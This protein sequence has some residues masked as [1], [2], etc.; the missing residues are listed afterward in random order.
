MRDSVRLHC[1]L[2]FLAAREFRKRSLTTSENRVT[3]FE[4]SH[5]RTHRLYFSGGIHARNR[6]LRFSHTAAH[7]A[8]DVCRHEMRIQRID[9]RGPDTDQDLVGFWHRL[10]ELFEFQDVARR[11]VLAI[12]HGFHRI[13]LLLFARLGLSG[14]R[15]MYALRQPGVSEKMRLWRPWSRHF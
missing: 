13:M 9:G 5:I 2:R 12:D 8:T 10:L 1:E 3:R 15:N 4:A 11:P 7:H 14:I 6:I